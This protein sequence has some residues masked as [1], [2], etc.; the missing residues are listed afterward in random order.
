MCCLWQ[1][2]FVASNA[3]D[4]VGNGTHKAEDS[5][6]L[7]RLGDQLKNLSTTQYANSFLSLR[8]TMD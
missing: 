8:I 3:D 4:C 7:E 5:K 1:Q 2:H 6:S